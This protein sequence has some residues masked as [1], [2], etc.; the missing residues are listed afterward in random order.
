MTFYTHPFL[1]GLVGLTIATAIPRGDSI[2]ALSASQVA[3]FKPFSYYAATAYCKPATVLNKSC[4]VNCDANT[5]FQPIAAGGDGSK[6]QFWY[7]GIDLSLKTVIVGHQGTD[8]SKIAP[9]LTD[10][11][12]FLKPLNETFFPGLNSAIKIHNQFGDQHWKTMSQILSATRA[13]LQKSNLTQ[14]TLIGHS[15]GA[16]LALLDSV[17]LPLFLPGIQFKTIGY[18][19]PR[20]GNQAFADYVDAN[21]QLSHVNNR[22]DFVPVI[23]LRT[24]GFVQPQGEKHIQDDLTWLDCPG[25]DN[26]DPRCSAGDVSSVSAGNLSN[27]DGPYDGVEMG[28]ATCKNVTGTAG[29]ATAAAS[30][31]HARC[32]VLFLLATA[33]SL[34]HDP[35]QV[36]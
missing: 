34:L 33:F 25:N 21:V 4:G 15:L 36:L 6:I 16:A 20:V 28:G 19:L 27:H 10:A 14:V 18:G 22:E 30:T 9:L 31:F 11:N 2:T 1:F 17:S 26:P 32:G 5:A 23:P 8:P 29:V 7:V 3:A 12:F 35:L 13:A 24:L